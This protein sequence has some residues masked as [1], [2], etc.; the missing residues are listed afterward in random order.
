MYTKSE[1]ATE[2]K[3]KKKISQ[4]R[5]D[6]RAKEADR[7]KSGEEMKNKRETRRKQSNLLMTHFLRQDKIDSECLQPV[8]EPE[9]SLPAFG[10]STGRLGFAALSPLP[11]KLR[12]SRLPALRQPNNRL[13]PKCSSAANSLRL[14]Q[15]C[16]RMS[17]REYTPAVRLRLAP[18]KRP[19]RLLSSMSSA[20]CSCCGPAPVCD[21][22][23][24]CDGLRMSACKNS[25]KNTLRIIVMTTRGR[26]E[27]STLPES[28]RRPV[29][30]K[31]SSN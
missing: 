19:L 1:R 17:C 20:L 6:Q 8:E 29:R 13:R 31:E 12:L 26:K 16:S 7:E 10:C 11:V 2:K 14:I 27:Q 22:L 25:K 28:K 21:P 9:V 15:Y 3:K 4:A 24:R 18:F 23:F 5:S 30:T